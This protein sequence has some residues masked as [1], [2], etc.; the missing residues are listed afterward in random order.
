MSGITVE[1]NGENMEVPAHIV[2]AHETPELAQQTYLSGLQ[3]FHETDKV[4]PAAQTENQ[5]AAAEQA[6]AEEGKG[7]E[8]L[9]KTTD[10]A[11]A[12]DFK[13]TFGEKYESAEQ[14]KA[15]LAR[16]EE[17]DTKES[18]LTSYW[19]KVREKE[20]ILSTAENPVP[21]KFRSQIEFFKATNIANPEVISKVLS[22]NKET[23]TKDP[24]AVLTAASLLQDTDLSEGDA[25]WAKEYRAICREKGVDP[26]TPYQELS[27]DEKETLERLATKALKSVTEKTEKISTGEDFYTSLQNKRASQAQAVESK[28]P[29][30]KAE[31]SNFDVSKVT[32]KVGDSEISLEAPKD[33]LKSIPDNMIKDL[34]SR[35]DLSTSQGKQALKSDIDSY[36]LLSMIESGEYDKQIFDK[37][38]LKGQEDLAANKFNGKTKEVIDRGAMGGGGQQKSE[39]QKLIDKKWGLS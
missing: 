35:H 21:E 19:D 4:E 38:Y 17:Y 31:I 2:A 29:L 9:E 15:R 39:T 3:K 12:F 1:F 27:D 20:Q 10:A 16:A 37:A 22:I 23:I 32:R 8:P 36:V 24:V 34:A 28:V 13:T 6:A 26:N 14:I 5:N 7:K 18:E 33:I 25:A 30:I 11:T